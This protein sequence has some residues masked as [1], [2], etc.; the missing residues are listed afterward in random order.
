MNPDA[1]W[2]YFY[3]QVLAFVSVALD[4][5]VALPWPEGQPDGVYELLTFTVEETAPAMPP[6]MT[7]TPRVLEK[8]A[9]TLSETVWSPGQVGLTATRQANALVE[10]KA[11]DPP[12]VIV[13]PNQA[14]GTYDIRTFW[15]R[16]QP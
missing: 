7:L 1:N 11:T 14:G 6:A 4:T 2:S 5:R 8:A 15:R 3:A 16:R 13:G 12:N 9:S 10:V